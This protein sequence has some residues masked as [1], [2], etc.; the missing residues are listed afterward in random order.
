MCHEYMGHKVFKNGPSKICGGQP[1]DCLKPTISL[2][3]FKDCFSQILLGP[4][5]N[6]LCSIGRFKIKKK[7]SN[8]SCIHPEAIRAFHK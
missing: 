7:S 2:Q 5:S 4:F 8:N 3:I 1:F 6:I